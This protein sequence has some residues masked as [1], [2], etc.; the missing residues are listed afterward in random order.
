MLLRTVVTFVHGREPLTATAS[1]RTQ[2]SASVSG[3]S[4]V[5]ISRAKSSGVHVSLAQRAR[6]HGVVLGGRERAR[7]RQRRLDRGAAAL[8]RA[9]A[10]AVPGDAGRRR[11]RGAARPPRWRPNPPVPSEAAPTTSSTTRA[12]R[13][14]CASVVMRSSRCLPQA[15]RCLQERRTRACQTWVRPT[16]RSRGFA[17][18][19]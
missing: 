6:D 8:V 4:F 18:T 1:L 5:A 3:S 15:G 9:H 19:Q 10:R 13:R 2:Q 11:R 14:T 12:C 7:G 17:P 16:R